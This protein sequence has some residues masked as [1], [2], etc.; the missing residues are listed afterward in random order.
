VAKKLF[1]FDK[2]G[3]QPRPLPDICAELECPTYEELNTTGCGYGARKIKGTTWVTT[4]FDMGMKEAS[5][6]QAFWRLFMYISGNNDEGV[7]MPMTVPVLTQVF[8]DAEYKPKNT[9]YISFYLSSDYQ[10]PAPAPLDADVEINVW[11]EDVVIYYSAFGGQ[12]Y[13]SDKD[14]DD[15]FTKLYEAVS[16]SGKQIS[17][18][19]VLTAGYTRPGFGQQRWEA[20]YMAAEE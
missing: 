6:M 14:W 2:A 11:D 20:I 3:G 13:P 4:T 8:L 1:S 19:Q 5:Y 10:T 7:K 12:G 17:G 16:K 15:K 9:A 18:Q